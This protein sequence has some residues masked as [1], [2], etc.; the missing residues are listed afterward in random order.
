M[1]FLVFYIELIIKLVYFIVILQIN[2]EVKMKKLIL[3]AIILLCGTIGF[4]QEYKTYRFDNGHTVIIGEVTSNP[5][6]IIDTW[7]KTGSIA[8]TD[9]NNGV[10]H[11]LEHL[12][13]KG[14]NAHPTGEFDKLLEGKG[15]VINAATSKDFTHYFIEI[16]SEYFDMAVELHAD[17]LLNPQIPRKELEKERKVV[18]EEIYKDKNSPSEI[19]YDNLNELLYTTHPYKRKVIGKS[20]VIGTITREEILDFYNK[21]YSPSNMVTV[22]I[23]D[24]KTEQVLQKIKEVFA[25]DYK[26]TETKKFAKEKLLHEQKRK[27]VNMESESGYLMI[28][29]RG[30]SILEDD[31]YA[32]DILATIL[33]DGRTSKLY[34]SIKEQ[35][36]LAYSI[37]A[38]N[39]SMRDDGIFYINANFEPVNEQKL[40]QAIFDEINKIKLN[41]ITEDELNLAK[42]IIER[43]TYY[44]R[45]SISNI[46]SEIGYTVSLTNDANYYKNYLSNIDKITIKEVQ[47]VANKYLGENRSAI[48]LCVPEV[49]VKKEINDENVNRAE[50]VDELNQTKKYS[51][52]NGATLLITD[53]NINDIVAMSI[54][55]KGGNF[56]EKIA[57][58]GFLTAEVMMKGTYN[59]SS[60]EL[61]NVLE[62]N[63]IKISPVA[64]EDMF[65]I[66][67]LTTKNQVAKTLELLSELLNNAKI[68][69]YQIEKKRTE[70]LNMIK[71]S[72][73]IP[74]NLAL[75]EYKTN[76]FK[77]SV[78]SN[79]ATILE[80]SLPKIQRKDVLDY[81]NK[82][83]NPNNIVISVNGSVDKDLLIKEFNKMFKFQYSNK[84]SYSNYKIPELEQSRISTKRIKD[85]K[86]AWLV[87]GW[88]TSGLNNIKDTVTLQVI[89]TILGSGMSSRLFG[90]IREQE[91]LAYQIGSSFSAK[92]LSG[93]LTVYMGTNPA[94]VEIAK[95]KLMDEVYRFKSEFVSDKELQAAKDRLLG[96]YVISLETNSRKAFA[97]GWYEMS[98]RGFKLEDEYKK[99]VKSV[100]ASDI[101]E[102]ANKYFNDKYVLSIVDLGEN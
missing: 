92:M 80:K 51:L 41:G 35:K 11:F 82:I 30:A 9:K 96:E 85:L 94:N 87:M 16:P 78:Y 99:L 18:L 72:R 93:A 55:V 23:G 44:A 45:E 10:A 56:V 53:N 29:F 27:V 52:G 12:F 24:V 60:S 5:I 64:S 88:R 71:Q 74:L 100:T 68:D 95:K 39:T 98:G 3:I 4:S 33:G 66:S 97:L 50:L 32:L 21:N 13:F 49:E 79:S 46:S 90:N 34:Q 28:G 83:F 36:Q 76:I 20:E 61:A 8:E 19:V 40:E 48:S 91:G 86:A 75:E 1:W 63:G 25:C 15:A 58:T 59:Y 81:Y 54:F 102:V 101:V 47:R 22:V 42:K 17:M 89:D 65:E 26:K 14:T 37:G 2:Y 62:G 73:D 84:F 43:N 70:K 7:V 77:E 6:V 69:D 67:V 57:G 38:S 31:T